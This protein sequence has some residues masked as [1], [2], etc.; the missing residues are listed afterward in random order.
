[1]RNT[2]NTL[3]VTGAFAAEKKVSALKNIS[4]LVS[5]S[6]NEPVTKV[7]DHVSKDEGDHAPVPGPQGD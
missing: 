3:I 4:F 5:S 2:G 1:V 7:S 6:E